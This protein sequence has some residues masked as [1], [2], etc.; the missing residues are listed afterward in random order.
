MLCESCGRYIP[1]DDKGKRTAPHHIVSR[2][3]GGCDMDE[4]KLN[5][6]MEC[7]MAYHRMGWKTFILK[8][9]HL[10]EKII[11]ARAAGGK[12]VD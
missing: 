11:A 7:H 5:L 1:E 6:C 10:K 8:Y 4:N 9:S 3:A 2:G 12:K